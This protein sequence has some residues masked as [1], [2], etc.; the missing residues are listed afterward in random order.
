MCIYYEKLQQYH[1]DRYTVP[2]FNGK[3]RTCLGPFLIFII[4]QMMPVPRNEKHRMVG[5]LVNGKLEK[6]LEEKTET[7][8]IF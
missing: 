6:M 7:C 3:Q 8:Y 1:V 4:L 2:V 5:W